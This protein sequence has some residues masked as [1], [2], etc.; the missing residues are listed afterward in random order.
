M[1]SEGRIYASEGLWPAIRDDGSLSQVVDVAGLPGIVGPSIAMPDAHQGYGFPIGGVAAT[2]ER[3]GVVSPG[4]VGFDINCG[5]RLLSSGLSAP[6]VRA[7]LDPLLAAV[8][9][10][11][12]V[13]FDAARDRSVSGHAMDDLLA[14]GAAWAVRAGWG[15]AED[16]DRIED[17]G[18]FS[19]ADPAMVSARA[20][21][22][23]RDQVGTLGSG[24]HFVE[25]QAV[26][27]VDD[28]DAARAMGLVEGGVAVLLHTGS[29]G[30]GHQVCTDQLVLMQQAMRRYGI[31]VA[32][33]QLACAP[34]ASEEG[35]AYL[36]AMGAAANY[37]WANRQ[38]L[39]HL[40]G[41]AFLEVFGPLADLSVVY[42]V[43][44]NIARIER[45]RVDGRPVPLC[46]HRKGAT[47]AF[48]AGHPDLPIGVRALGQ[49]VFIPG[50]MG[51]ASWVLLGT[52]RALDETWGSVCHGAGRTL[53]RTA[54]RRGRSAADVLADLAARGVTVHAGSRKG[55]SEEAPE[56][57]KD[58]DLV[59]GTVVGAGLALP[60]ARLVPMGVIK[61]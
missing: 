13:G 15:R 22:R 34:V 35:R 37:A 28:P 53:S 49:P 47:R 17:R 26:E 50:S 16:L 9:R 24:N 2:S 6:E 44:H 19:T 21:E 30:L 55:L 1:R 12:P 58:V 57:Y 31:R 27:A 23:G 52:E 42:D 60:V 59:V 8:A 4:G 54:A 43:A 56:S 41:E 33:R 10:R 11:V 29:R 48:P 36:G 38:V 51:T 14:Q 25:V 5:V 18:T 45:H 39:T 3:D 46:V 20:R 7:R 32:D 61:G 40:I